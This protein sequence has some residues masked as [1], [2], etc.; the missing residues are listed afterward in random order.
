MSIDKYPILSGIRS[1]ADVKALDEKDIPALCS[2][3]RRELVDVVSENGGHLASN[4]GVVELTVALHRCFDSPKDKIIFDVGHQCYVHKLLTG[5]ADEFGT[6]RTEGGLSGFTRPYESG[7]D[8]FFSGHSSTALSAAYG[9]AEANRL[10]GSDAYAVAVIGDG[11]FTGGEVY[12]AMNNAGRRDIRL[13][14]VLN[15][16][17]MSISPNVGALA[18]YFAAIKAD[19]KYFR[20]KARAEE[21]INRIPLIGASISQGIAKIKT[22]LKNDI[23]DSTLFEE[24]GFRYVGPIDGHDV[25]KL[26]KAFEAAKEIKHYPVLIHVNTV[27]GKGYSFAEEDPAGYHGVGRFDIRT[28]SVNVG[29]DNFSCEFGAYL[30]NKAAGDDRICAL[31]AAMTEG[32]GL[33]GFAKTYPDRFFDTGIAEQHSV[34]F[35]SGLAKGGLLPVFAV[36]SSF[37]QRAYDQVLHDAALQ[38][39]KIVFCVDRAGFVGSDGETHQ[40]LYDAAFLNTIPSVTVWS[41]SCYPDMRAALDQ[42]L[43]TD[44]GPSAV[45]I[46]RGKQPVMPE[47]YTTSGDSFDLFGDEDAGIALVSYGRIFSAVCE[48]AA[49]LEKRGTPCRIVKLNRIK[50]I[51]GGAVDDTVGRRKVFFFEEGQ[52]DGGVAERF[53]DMLCSSGF[54]GS[55]SCVA[56][57]DCFVPQGDV[58]RQLAAFGLDKNGVIKT[59]TDLTDPGEADG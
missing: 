47:W 1:P 43:Y 30:T 36:Y 22:E 44:H 38:G 15:D 32:T 11:A 42:A 56:V 21:M 55:W 53:L 45:R 51:D 41:P 46:P 23:Y 58:D 4:L 49:E 19:P 6:L 7:H 39:L 14:V 34:T 26:S 13:I 17:E 16:N 48:A 8:V 9:I 31:T 5:R 24:L 59:V 35:A 2:E 54:H 25:G 50:P 52:R 12:E 27:K 37:L 57:D 20:L 28:G 40:G 33:S 18:R 10:R 3:I 29:T